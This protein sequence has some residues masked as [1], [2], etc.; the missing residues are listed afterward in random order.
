MQQLSSETTISRLITNNPGAEFLELDAVTLKTERKFNGIY[1]NKV[2]HHLNDNELRSS[3]DRQ[4]Q[5]LLPGGIICHSFWKGEGDEIH[6]GLF[7]NYHSKLSLRSLFEKY[8]DFLVLENY[9]EFEN[10]DSILLIGRKK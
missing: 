6:K 10:E 4:A 1:S 5:K 3:I 7:V 2:L 9:K 8:F